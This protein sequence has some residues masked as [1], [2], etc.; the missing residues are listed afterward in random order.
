[1]TPDV[2]P[3]EPGATAR[4]WAGLLFIFGVLVTAICGGLRMLADGA[5]GADPTFDLWL[6]LVAVVTT[7]STAGLL[8]LVAREYRERR[9]FA[10]GIALVAAGAAATVGIWSVIAAT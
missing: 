7:A 6:W 1:M 9:R 5:A 10:I 3:V 4:D 8:V 2:E